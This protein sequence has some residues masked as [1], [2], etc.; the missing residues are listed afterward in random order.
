MYALPTHNYEKEDSVPVKIGSFEYFRR[1][2]PG[3]E[4]PIFV[5]RSSKNSRDEIILDVNKLAS[6]SEFF[7][8]QNHS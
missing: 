4:Y 3:N 8:I 7:Q 1:Y 2:K 6:N 5:R